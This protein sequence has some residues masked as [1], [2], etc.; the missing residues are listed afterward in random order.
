MMLY[1]NTESMVRSPDGDTDFFNITKGVLQG[2]TLAPYLFVICLDY[3]MRK[4]TEDNTNL[5][6]TLKQQTSRRHPPDMI[7]DADYADD[8]CITS[9]LLND[10]TVLLHRIEEAS[11]KIGLCLN[12][13]KT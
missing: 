1:E 2:D 13:K 7:T 9:D 8:L 3:I 4:A 12:A 10:A 6:F 11:I 5:G